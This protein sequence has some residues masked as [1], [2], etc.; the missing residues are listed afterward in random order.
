MKKI[1]LYISIFLLG[2]IPFYGQQG[3]YKTENAIIKFDAAKGNIEP[4]KAENIKAKLI[5]K[6][7]TGEIACL[8]D[9]TN[10]E[11][12]NKLM[13]EHF[14]ENYIESDQYPKASFSGKIDNFINTDFS[15]EQT[16]NLK[17]EFKIHGVSLTKTIPISVLKLNNTYNIKSNFNL[18]IKDFDIK[19]PSIMFYKIA[20]EVNVNLTAELKELQ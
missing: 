12:P 19:I 13:Q 11:F 14:N 8:M 5:L 16:L 4:I 15:K 1:L 18:Q 20:E 2:T 6:D 17:G 7:S 9:M 3:I 10:F